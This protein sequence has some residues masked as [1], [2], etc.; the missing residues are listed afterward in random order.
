MTFNGSTSENATASWNRLTAQPGTNFCCDHMPGYS[1]G[2][3]E[4]YSGAFPQHYHSITI[5]A[6]GTTSSSGSGQSHNNLQPYMTAQMWKYSGTGSTSGSVVALPSSSSNP[7][8]FEPWFPL[9]ALYSA[10]LGWVVGS[11]RRNVPVASG[12]YAR[13][14]AASVRAALVPYVKTQ[15][16]AA[17]LT[18]HRRS[19]AAP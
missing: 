9:A 18:N 19:C 3:Y 16:A 15:L 8:P 4:D 1:P 13:V 5:N 14:A 10:F 6:S 2:Y 12:R 17:M 7:R 11:R